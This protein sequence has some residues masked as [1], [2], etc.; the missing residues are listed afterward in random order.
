MNEKRYCINCGCE[1][2]FDDK[3]LAAIKKLKQGNTINLMYI[4][5]KGPDGKEIQLRGLPIELN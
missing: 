3:V 5:A 2:K 4:K 1:N